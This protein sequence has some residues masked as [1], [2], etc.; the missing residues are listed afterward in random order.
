[1]IFAISI[2]SSGHGDE[3][4]ILYIPFSVSPG[5]EISKIDIGKNFS[6]DGYEIGFEKPENFYAL[7]IGSFASEEEAQKY[8][9]KLKSAILWV[10][11]KYMIGLSMPNELGAVTLMD[12]PKPVPEKGPIRNIAEIAGWNAIDGYYDADKSIVRPEHKRLTRWETGT[13]TVIASLGSDNFVECLKQALSFSNPEKVLTDSKL[14]L[15]IEL[16]SS[17]FFEQSTNAKF[18]RLVTV[19]EALTP[20]YSMP[21]SCKQVVDEVKNY[22]K[23][24]RNEHDSNASEWKEL[25]SLLSR[26]GQLKKTSIGMSVRTYI[27]GLIDDNPKLGDKEEV[28]NK[29]KELYNHRSKL[30]HEGETDSLAVQEGLQFLTDFIPKLLE[31][32][33]TIEAEALK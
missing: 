18:I 3:R 31:F 25:E 22:I 5:R 1:M 12:A 6:I 20:N 17:F 15:A 9:P 23:S 10:S 14:K 2:G 24:K 28:I 26:V 13:A 29:L 11:L 27:S 8:F 21:E 33:Y 16:Y 7:T 4:Y 19:L 32:L 30:L